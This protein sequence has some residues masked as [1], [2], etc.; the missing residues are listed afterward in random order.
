MLRKQPWPENSG[1]ASATG[2]RAARLPGFT[3]IELLVVIA[4]ISILAAMLLP[5]LGSSKTAARRV[6]CLNNLNQMGLA[7]QIYLGDNA[8][9]YPIAQYDSTN[10]TVYSWD[11]TVSND[12]SGKPSVVPGILWE[13]QGNA[14]VQQCPS[15]SVSAN[16]PDNPYTGYNYNTSYIGH[17]QGEAIEQPAKD[18][19]VMQPSKTVLF[20]DGQYVGGAD[21]YMRAPYPNPGDDFGGRWAGTQGFRHLKRTNVAYTDGH[22][23]SLST[24]YTNNADGADFVAPGTGFLSADNSAYDLN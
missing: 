12:A 7:A 17:G 19:D 23:T 24:I 11:L 15:Y 22:G 9:Y 14:Q 18:S 21:K 8:N 5:V 13:G 1:S 16:S 3:L 4:I 20:G 2:G 10:G 6:Q